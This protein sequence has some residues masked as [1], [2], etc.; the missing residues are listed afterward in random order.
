MVM[1]NLTDILIVGLSM[2]LRL[3]MIWFSKNAW[4]EIPELDS[5]GIHFGR[6]PLHEV[7]VTAETVCATP[8]RDITTI[9]IICFRTQKYFSG[10]GYS[11]LGSWKDGLIMELSLVQSLN[12]HKA[13]RAGTDLFPACHRTWY[14]LWWVSM[15][16]YFVMIL[17][18]WYMLH[19][20]KRVGCFWYR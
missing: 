5:V 7:S 20:A 19:K 10:P 4:C 13:W 18:I 17:M 9:P 8:C 12:S 3:R 2:I 14:W 16:I 1:D 6:L 15:S 11:A